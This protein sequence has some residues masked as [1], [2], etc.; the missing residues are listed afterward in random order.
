MIT[1]AR[2]FQFFFAIFLTFISF[3][4]FATDIIIT[5]SKV[6]TA[7]NSSA[8]SLFVIDQKMIKN[9]QTN[10]LSELLNDNAMIQVNN[11]GP[12]GTTTLHLKGAETGHILVILDGLI[13][14]DPINTNALFDFNQLNLQ[15]IEKIEILPGSQSVIYG[16]SAI[17]GVIN[18]IS[19]ASLSKS[20][21]LVGAG[22]H[23][24][25]LANHHLSTSIGKTIINLGYSFEKSDGYNATTFTSNLNP[26]KDGFQKQN[27]SFVLQNEDN[28]FADFQ[29]SSRIHLTENE[30][31][32]GFN[33]ERDDTNFNADDKFYF[34]SL[35]IKPNIKNEKIEPEI[36]LGIS[37]ADRNVLDLPDSLGSTTDTQ[38]YQSQ[39][40]QLKVHNIFYL[41]NED[42]LISGLDFNYETGSFDLNLSGSKTIF[43]EK[44]E[45]HY[46]IY[47]HY[48]K[49]LNPIILNLGARVEYYRSN[50]NTVFKAGPSYFLKQHKLKF[51]SL[52][53]TGFKSPSLYQLH[54]QFG[55]KNLESEKSVHLEVGLEKTLAQ[56]SL[57][58][59]LFKTDIEDLIDLAG[60]YPN[61][62]YKNLNEIKIEGITAE[63]KKSFIPDFFNYK[64]STQYINA[65]N[66]L[67]NQKLINRPVLKT[68]QTAEFTLGM[69][70]FSLTHIFTSKKDGGTTASPVKLSEN[71]IFNGTYLYKLT[72]DFQLKVQIKN[73][74]DL[75]YEQVSGFETGGRTWKVNAEYYY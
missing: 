57:N 15:S 75:D 63:F 58:F 10:S 69:H 59:S 8:S 6:K 74:F 25:F 73:I 11:S 18:I 21:I 40:V 61:S 30:L 44:G 13:L 33:S 24:T 72:Q 48:Q 32:K 42:I 62:Q 68:T 34:H 16:S 20:S 28:P 60:V 64:F 49:N 46:G 26:E 43:D 22:N 66:V 12:G 27:I 47:S 37:K 55:N 36:Y 38:T 70:D 52:L 1:K 2:A 4:L 67:T 45:S 19:K 9:S 51:Y 7:K 23:D 53:S 31:D 41:D 14:N 54:S 5:A 17:G 71:H 56:G 65:Y 29:L 39:I 3:K 50:I 35:K